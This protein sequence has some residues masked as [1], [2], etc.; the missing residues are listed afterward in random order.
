MFISRM[1]EELIKFRSIA[2]TSDGLTGGE[3]AR[4]IGVFVGHELRFNKVAFVSQVGYYVYWPYEFENRVYNRL[5][6]KRYITENLFG[7]VTV[8]A[9]YAKAEAVEFSIGIRL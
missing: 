8:K 7:S 1:I 4:R 6:L 9:H 5:G 2:F 3:D